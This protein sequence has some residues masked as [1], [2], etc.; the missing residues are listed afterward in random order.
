LI[1]ALVVAAL[2]ATWFVALAVVDPWLAARLGMNRHAIT[3]LA[4]VVAVMATA[5]ALVFARLAAVRD[6]LLAGRRVLGRWSV[7]AATWNT[8]APAAL[9]ADASERR[10]ALL[11]VLF[12]VV[13][14]FGGFALFDPEA[15][16][17]M[18]LFGVVVAI[19]VI[20]AALLGARVQEAHWRPTSCEVIV[21]AR[22]LLVNGVLHV[23]A[24]PLS[25][26]LGA[27]LVTH[28]RALV[29]TYG[30]FA[31]SGRQ[32]VE[33]ILP[34]PP[35]AWRTAGEVVSALAEASGH[36]PPPTRA[37]SPTEGATATHQTIPSGRPAGDRSDPRP[38]GPDRSPPSRGEPS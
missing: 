27:R 8:V 38:G 23:W 1:V 35:T 16:P 13:L 25:R 6:E 24:L 15:A 33:V 9:A 21:G 18:I 17:A 36:R 32:D 10:S 4:I 37:R 19:A 29:V 34:V 7:D 3:F 12:F 11:A 28:P 22:G 2:C 14:G 30:W 5:T 20:L 26:L 31:R